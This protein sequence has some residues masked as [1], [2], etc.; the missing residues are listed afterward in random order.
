[1]KRDL[2]D[3]Q[4]TTKESLIKHQVSIHEGK[5]YPCESFI[6]EETTRGG[7]FTVMFN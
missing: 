3:Y 5:T 2:C 7:L 6:S 4:A 1:M